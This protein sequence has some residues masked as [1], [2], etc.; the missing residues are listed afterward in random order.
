MSHNSHYLKSPNFD[1]RKTPIDLLVIHYTGMVS[2]EAALERLCDP[3]AK[4]SAHYVIDQDGQIYC[5]VDESHRAWHAGLG[6][7]GKLSNDINSRAIGIELVNSGHEHG[8]HPFAAAQI[9]ALIGLCQDILRRHP[10]ISPQNVVGHSDIAPSRKL[11]PGELFPW[12]QLALSG[13]GL[14]PNVPKMPIERQILLRPAD[15][16]AA[17][18]QLQ[19]SLADYG[20]GVEINGVYD[21]HLFAVVTAWQRHF[22]PQI[23]DGVWDAECAQICAEILVIARKNLPGKNQQ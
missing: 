5:L 17:V 15:C 12:P 3:A 16:G 19:S 18:R 7:W 21:P 14:Y 8:Y 6:R 13:I 23:C 10:H 11:D 9:D 2:A 4:V 1:A 22:R 20:Y